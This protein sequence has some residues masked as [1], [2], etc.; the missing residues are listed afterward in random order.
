[1]SLKR[2]RESFCSEISEPKLTCEGRKDSRPFFLRRRSGFTV[3]EASIAVA[4]LGLAMVLTAQLGVWVLAE[5]GYHR[6][7]QAAEE[8]AANVL[9]AAR[10]CRW[11]ALTPAWA[12]QQRLP[13]PFDER[14]WRLS[15]RVEDEPKRPQTRRVTVTLQPQW[16]RPGPAQ[17]VQ[18]VSLFTARTAP[19]K[20]TKP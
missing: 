6:D 3:L 18:L 5:R 2:G 8:I 14:D 1:M 15:V 19:V 9:E 12:A 16:E 20:G 13:A 10:A 17:P 7:R 11:E 4:V